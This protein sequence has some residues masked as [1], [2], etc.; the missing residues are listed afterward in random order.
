MRSTAFVTLVA[1]VLSLTVALTASPAGACTCMFDADEDVLDIYDAVFFGSVIDSRDDAATS[2]WLVEVDSIVQGQPPALTTIESSTTHCGIDTPQGDVVVFFVNDNFRFPNGE[3]ETSL[4]SPT[5]NVAD[6]ATIL[7]SLPRSTPTD[8]GDGALARFESAPAVTEAE[9]EVVESAAADEPLI[10]AEPEPDFE[11][12]EPTGD[13]DE[14]DEPAEPAEVAAL[15][16]ADVVDGPAGDEELAAPAS[17]A[18]ET[19]DDGG[20]TGTQVALVAIVLVAGAGGAV[21]L[22]RRLA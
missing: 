9:V 5:R 16:E 21:A 14:G 4:C 7:T 17:P 18:A 11:V 15:E 2:L 12:V 13:A 19:P 22:R 20:S 10:V 1:L 6:P 8:A 3:Y